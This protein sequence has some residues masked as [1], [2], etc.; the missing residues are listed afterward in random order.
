M[1]RLLIQEMRE[2]GQLDQMNEALEQLGLYLTYGLLPDDRP[3][4]GGGL[5]AHS[6]AQQKEERGT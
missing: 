1:T 6:F 2:S 3:D 5:I 4:E